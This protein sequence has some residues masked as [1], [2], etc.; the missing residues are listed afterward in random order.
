MIPAKFAQKLAISALFL[1]FFVKIQ[2]QYMEAGLFV[3]GANYRGDL[4]EKYHPDEWNSTYGL[5]LRYFFSP[6]FVWKTGFMNGQIT[7]SDL[8]YRSNDPRHDRNLSFRTQLIE[9]STQ[10][11]YSLFKYDVLDGKV[12]T[13]Y[14]FGGIGATYF[15]PQAEFRGTWYDL[16]DL[17]TEGQGWTPGKK[18]YSQVAMVV[19]MG[20]GFR[21]ALGRRVNLGF[22]VG[23]RKS[24]SDFLDDVSGDY[25]D[26]MARAETD[27]TAA[28]L[29]FRTPELYGDPLSQ[30]TVTKRGD[31]TKKDSYLF[32]GVC[33]NFN[34]TDQ[35]GLEWDK[36]YRIHDAD[37]A[38]HKAKKGRKWYQFRKKNYI[39]LPPKPQSS[40]P[41]PNRKK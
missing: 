38:S 39:S 13:P 8:H 26:V 24:F 7:G 4:A 10:F 12:S 17:G 1:M 30:P 22:E 41:N 28:K 18:K 3:G 33:I 11:E 9:L 25:A 23:Y 15:N 27:Y 20:V 37:I 40:N 31:P 36:K 5:S 19:P 29:S 2:A 16:R 32:A 21:F 14:L 35:Y 34:L 6:K